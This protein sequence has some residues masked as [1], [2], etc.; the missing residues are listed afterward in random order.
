M[1]NSTKHLIRVS[2]L[3]GCLFSLILIFAPVAE[4]KDLQYFELAEFRDSHSP[5]ETKMDRDFLRKLDRLRDLVG[6]PIHIN[7]GY[8]SPK[9]PDE[10]YKRTPGTHNKGIAADIMAVNTYQRLRILKYAL[11]LGFTGI[12]IYPRHIHLDTRNSKQVLWV[13]DKYII[14]H[15]RD[16]PR[17]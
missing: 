9:H 11:Q 5:Y 12:G 6:F 17:R 14:S 1:K 13:R 8:R 4:A 15:S 7:S 3:L 2:V 10:S 16:S